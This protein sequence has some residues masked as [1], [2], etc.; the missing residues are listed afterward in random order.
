MCSWDRLDWTLLFGRPSFPSCSHC[1][2]PDSDNQQ[3]LPALQD[4]CCKYVFTGVVFL[5]PCSM[6]T[7][8]DS[9]NCAHKFC[10]YNFAHEILQC[11]FQTCASDVL[12]RDIWDY[13]AVLKFMS[14]PPSGVKF[15]TFKAC[16]IS[17]TFQVLE[18]WII[19]SKKCATLC[20]SYPS[21]VFVVLNCSGTNTQLVLLQ[22]GEF[23]SN[24]LDF[25]YVQFFWLC[26]GKIANC[27]KMMIIES[28][29]LA[30]VVPSVSTYHTFLVL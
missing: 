24:S 19:F 21:C 25:D 22:K 9:A 2:S 3:L 5:T 17:K 10:D 11:L 8:R 15:Q 28:R 20:D 7:A 12:S 6:V 18:K 23:M 1:C 30:N 16:L 26:S 4:C 29:Y 14:I 27:L 13:H